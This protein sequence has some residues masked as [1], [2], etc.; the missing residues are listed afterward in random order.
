[1]FL[2]TVPRRIFPRGLNFFTMKR[3]QFLGIACAST[4]F[5][6]ACKKDEPN[7]ATTVQ[8]TITDAQGKPIFGLEVEFFGDGGGA[9][10]GGIIFP[11][12]PY[13]SFS[14][15]TITDPNGFFKIIKV[16]P[17]GI[18]DIEIRLP[19]TVYQK[20]TT[21]ES[22]KDGKIISDQYSGATLIATSSNIGFG[23]VNEYLVTLK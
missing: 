6:N 17:D 19:N 13:V 5:A 21:I 18:T 9:G 4:V 15:K 1:M 20:Y 3:R 8:G 22:K 23:K 14:E 12:S 2:P 16:L 10:S 7:P 11:S